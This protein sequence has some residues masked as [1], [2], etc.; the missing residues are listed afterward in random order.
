[1]YPIQGKKF[2][3]RLTEMTKTEMTKRCFFKTFI[4]CCQVNL[5]V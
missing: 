3:L 5:D 4:M 1:M 2:K